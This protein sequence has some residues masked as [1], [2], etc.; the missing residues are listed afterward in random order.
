MTNSV[1]LV[2]KRDDRAEDAAYWLGKPPEDR[3]AAVEFLRR[4]CLYAVGQTEMPR[5][6]RVARLV[7]RR[8]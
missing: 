4:Q 3:V 8:G 5:M 6:A 7:D 2:D 1:R